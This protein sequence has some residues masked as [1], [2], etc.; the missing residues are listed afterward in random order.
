MNTWQEDLLNLL[1]IP[2]TSPEAIFAHI[3]RATVQLGFEHVAFGFQAPYPVT[4]PNVTLLNNYPTAWQQ[5]YAQAGYLLTDPTVSHG[6]QSQTPIVWNDQAF[7]SNRALWADAQDHGI[8]TGWAQSCL[9]R[10]G[11]G[12]LLTLCRRAEPLTTSELQ[13]KEA[14]M[15]WLVQ[16]AHVILSRAVLSQEKI[17][18][19]ALTK[20]EREVLQWSA[21]GKSAQDIADI[22]NLSKGAVDFH[23]KNSI[24][25]LNAPNKTAAVARAALMGWLS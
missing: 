25:K 11:A 12:S 7:A 13:A 22:L 8:K 20:R 2:E 17:T 19:A 10:S 3:Q 4:N 5:R 18:Y 21:D 6:R 23:L 9:E 1:L 15:R 24:Q 14:S 16:V